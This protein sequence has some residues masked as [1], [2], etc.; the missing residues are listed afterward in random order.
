[1]RAVVWEPNVADLRI[2]SIERKKLKYF[3]DEDAKREGGYTLEQFKKVWKKT[4]GE[5]DEDQLV[6]V[7]L[8]EKL[9]TNLRSPTI[10]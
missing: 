8:F 3:N 4:H 10:D 9:Y 5:W 7:I 1:M 6:Y 2:T